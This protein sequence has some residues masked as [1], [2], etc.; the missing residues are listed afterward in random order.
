MGHG[1]QRCRELCLQNRGTTTGAHLALHLTASS[2]HSCLAF[3]SSHTTILCIAS[4][5]MSTCS[6]TLPYSIPVGTCLP[7]TFLLQGMETLED[8][9]F[10]VG[11]TVSDV[12]YIV[13]R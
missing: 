3:A 6:T 1:K 12:C 8:D 11:K 10:A 4:T 2:V 7:P 5:V 9:T 13:T